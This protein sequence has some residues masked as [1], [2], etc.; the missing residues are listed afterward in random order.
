M[1]INTDQ[2]V[3]LMVS[4]FLKTFAMSG[5]SR[6]DMV[7]FMNHEALTARSIMTDNDVGELLIDNKGIRQS[8]SDIFDI[9][10]SWLSGDSD[11]IWQANLNGWYKAVSLVAWCLLQHRVAGHI[12]KV[13]FLCSNPLGCLIGDAFEQADGVDDG[14]CSLPI[15]IYIEH[16]AQRRG[17]VYKTY[18]LFDAERWN[19]TNCRDHIKYVLMLCRNTNTSVEG[20][21]VR[22]NDF[23]NVFNGLSHP[24]SINKKH[25]VSFNPDEV[26]GEFS[27]TFMK[28]YGKNGQF[29]SAGSTAVALALEDYIN[30]PNTVQ[31][32]DA[33]ERH[34]L[35]ALQSS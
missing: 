12:N 20:Q 13:Y 22:K 30:H 16:V 9:S 10:M 24:K 15:S 6:V 17:Y 8:V 35:S 5:I 7:D 27:S 23:D 19:Y 34:N 31:N 18:T 33:L 29:D 28:S 14:S 26:F 3:S 32:N 25:I 21:V 1:N 2:K 4:R 11:V